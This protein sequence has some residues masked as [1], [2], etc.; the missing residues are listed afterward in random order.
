MPVLAIGGERWLGGA[1]KASFES[2]CDDLSAVVIAGCAH[3]VP[4]EAADPLTDLLLR[5]LAGEALSR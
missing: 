2:V 4:E 1:M 5:F 3:F